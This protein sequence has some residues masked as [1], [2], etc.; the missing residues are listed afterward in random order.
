MTT[1]TAQNLTLAY[2]SAPVVEN[3]SVTFPAGK[4]TALLGP[5]GSGKSTL[6]TAMAGLLK[7]VAGK[8]TLKGTEISRLSARER[9]R[10]IAFLPQMPVAPEGLSVRELV[11]LGRFPF[12]GLMKSSDAG[13][14]QAVRQA[15]TWCDLEAIA[16][17]PAQ[18]LSG[19]QR[20][21]VWIAMSLAQDADL[22]LLDEPTSFLDIAHQEEALTLLR[23]LN[24]DQGK[25]VITV[26]HDVN[27]AAAYADHI[28]MLKSGAVVAEGPPE[29]VVTSEH[30]ET[31]Y[32]LSAT[33]VPNPEDGTPLFVPRRDA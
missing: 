28:L 31:V 18:A 8:V 15:M 7:P 14:A 10:H 11:S 17:R 19:G 24:R 1:L 33:V 25:T 30:I 26:L 2:G 13:G 21:R 3:F 9:A 32:D 4:M 6:L 5:N 20:Q 12:R 23:R 29:H 22:L 27:Q 16:D